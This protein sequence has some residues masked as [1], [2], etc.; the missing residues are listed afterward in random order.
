MGRYNGIK[1][2]YI[3]VYGEENNCTIRKQRVG[4]SGT[5]S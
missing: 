1:H 2:L 5:T 3:I 4:Q